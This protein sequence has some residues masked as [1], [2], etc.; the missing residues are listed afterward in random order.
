M[1]K[2]QKA[3]GPSPETQAY[4]KILGGKIQKLR[5]I[6]GM[7]Q[8]TLA[9]KLG[10]SEKYMSAVENGRGG[11]KQEKIKKTA[12]IFNVQPDALMSEKDLTYEQLEMLRN[13]WRSFDKPDNTMNPAL[14]PLLKQAADEAESPSL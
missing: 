8:A 2:K 1:K 11:M 14:G 13:L 6:T 9:E 5:K 10:Y 3:K 12:E 7:T 4:R